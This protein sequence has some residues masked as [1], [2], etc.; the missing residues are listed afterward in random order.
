MAQPG[1]AGSQFPSE[2]ALI[3]RIQD[4]EKTVQQL[5]AANPFAPMGMTP[6]PNGVT[7]GGNITANGNLNVGG[8]ANFT[9]NTTIGGTASVTGDITKTNS[10][11]SSRLGPDI[12]NTAGAPALTFTK[13][14]TTYSSPVGIGLA[15]GKADTYDVLFVNGPHASDAPFL[16]LRSN[17][18][19]EIGSTSS[20]TGPNVY[21]EAGANGNLNLA[22]GG[23]NGSV[24]LFSYGTGNVQVNG[25]FAVTGSKA[26]T[27]DHPVHPDLMTLMHAA[28]ESPVNGVEYWGEAVAGADGAVTVELPS[29]FEA[30]TKPGGRNI[31]LTATE[32][33][34]MAPWASPVIDGKFTINAPAGVALH[35]L[36]KA[37]RQQ[38]V[39]GHDVLSFPAEQDKMLIGPQLPGA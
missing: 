32:A 38:V 27:M 24:K 2:D 15:R 6:N 8:T 34:D 31:Q 21:G 4:L 35:W 22:G 18:T 9:G 19:F 3:R 36:V 1:Q 5:A 39:D 23:T 13:V 29:Y 12:F 28:T 11:G 26:F 10:W 17:Q 14:G 33:C 20:N 25:N 7:F 16:N 37:E 30:L